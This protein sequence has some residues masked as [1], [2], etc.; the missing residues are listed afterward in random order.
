MER[1]SINLPN[2]AIP[3]NVLAT[4]ESLLKSRICKWL[5]RKTKKCLLNFFNEADTV[6]LSDLWVIIIEYLLH[7]FDYDVMVVRYG[8]CI[9]RTPGPVVKLA[10]DYF[11]GELYTAFM[12]YNKNPRFRKECEPMEIY[13]PVKSDI[14]NVVIRIEDQEVTCNTMSEILSVNVDWL[15]MLLDMVGKI[16]LLM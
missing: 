8:R 15:N 4:S 13:L 5:D 16:N 1:K 3:A 11:G 2:L 14:N 9:S 10:V 12:V 6:I 7:E